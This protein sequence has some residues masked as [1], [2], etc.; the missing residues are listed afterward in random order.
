MPKFSYRLCLQGEI[1]CS[2]EDSNVDIVFAIKTHVV[3]KL[4]ID[5]DS[6]LAHSSHYTDLWDVKQVSTA[7]CE[8]K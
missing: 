6:V 5:S 7:G 3:Y 1:F 2:V 4:H 8:N